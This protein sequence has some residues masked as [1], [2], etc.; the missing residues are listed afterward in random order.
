MKYRRLWHAGGTYFFT[1]NLFVR[2]DNDLLTKN[3][4]LLRS[5]VAKVRE[6]HPFAVH[7]WVVLP[8]HMHCILEMPPGDADFALRWRL[9]KS[10]FSKGLPNTEHRSAVRRTRGERGIWQ[11]RF[12]EH[13]IKDEQDLLTHMDYVHFNPVKHGL[14][15]KAHDWRYSTFH[16]MFEMVCTR[17]I[18]QDNEARWRNAL[19]LLRPTSVGDD[20]GYSTVV[21]RNKRSALR[22]SNVRRS[23]I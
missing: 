23:S 4:S 20:V 19:R 22:H 11:R 17:L 13:L 14:V 1:V 15:D 3:I 2:R 16:S 5:V 10:N 7:A 12:W 21:G 18:G 6:N 8:D 9:I